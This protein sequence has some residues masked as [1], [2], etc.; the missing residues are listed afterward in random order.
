MSGDLLARISTAR[1]ALRPRTSSGPVAWKP[2]PGPQA[3]FMVCNAFE[4]LYGGSAG[5]GKTESLL[6]DATREIKDPRYCGILFRRTFPELEK[7]LIARSR[8][9][10]KRLDPT[11]EYNEQKKCWRFSSGATIYFGHL[12]H[13]NDVEAYQSAEFQFLGFDEASHF[14][15]KQYRYMLSRARSSFGL[16]PRVRGG[17]NPGGRGHAWLLR[18]FAPWLDRSPEYSGVRAES[19]EILHVLNTRDGEQYVEP[20]T[21]GA[22]S[23]VF[24]RSRLTDNPFIMKNDPLYVQRLMGLDPVTRARLLD[25]DWSVREAAGAYFR[26]EWFEVVSES[27]M[28]G[29][30][31][32]CWDFASTEPSDTNPDPDWTSGVLVSLADDGFYYVEDIKRFRVGPGEVRARV[33]ATAESDGPDVTIRIPQD[34]GQA[35]KDQAASYIQ[36]LAGFD[37]RAEPVTGSKITRAGIASAQAHP[38]STGGSR[39][40]IRVVGGPWTEA[41]LAELED[42]PEGHDDQVDGFADAIKFL[43]AGVPSSEVGVTVIG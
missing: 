10:Y 5:G 25:G 26:R 9:Y 17:T 34:P 2:N 36:M 42:F 19:G 4:A 12:E 14:S 30:A 22:M 13:D 35:G 41:F 20:T 40:R 29:V 18:R 11:A 7:S 31:V 6:M 8:S 43:S 32:R 33:K 37:V 23:R 38:A 24:I 16:A 28:T 21:D 27:P 3:E 1:G 39:G 15:E